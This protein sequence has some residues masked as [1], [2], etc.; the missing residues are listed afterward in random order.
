VPCRKLNIA[1]YSVYMFL[2]KDIYNTICSYLTI[3]DISRL[4]RISKPARIFFGFIKFESDYSSYKNQYIIIAIRSKKT[5]D[6]V[7]NYITINRANPLPCLT[8]MHADDF[9]AIDLWGNAHEVIYI[10]K[11]CR[12]RVMIGIVGSDYP[13]IFAV[14]KLMNWSNLLSAHRGTHYDNYVFDWPIMNKIK[15]FISDNLPKLSNPNVLLDSRLVNF[16]RNI[17]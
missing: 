16:I 15:E 14:T 2:N 3:Q 4:V 7:D 6:I 12:T 17:S 10:D 9:C 8:Y 5:M 11:H 13:A 1:R